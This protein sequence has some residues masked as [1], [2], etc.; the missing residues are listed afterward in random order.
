M[1]QVVT[2]SRC[3]GYPFDKGFE[4]CDGTRSLDMLWRKENTPV[5][6]RVRFVMNAATGQTFSIMILPGPKSRKTNV[7]MPSPLSLLTL[8]LSTLVGVRGAGSDEYAKPS[9]PPA[10]LDPKLMFDPAEVNIPRAHS[11]S[12]DERL[13]TLSSF[14]HTR[15]R[16]RA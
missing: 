11:F 7:M 6:H 14:T 2:C 8:V 5:S 3:P 15:A 13:L 10:L 16:P 12:L 1:S 4:T 9:L